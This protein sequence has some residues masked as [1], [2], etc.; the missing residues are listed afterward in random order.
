MQDEN[1][2]KQFGE[3]VKQLRLQKRLSQEELAHL[4]NLDRSY[5][6]GVERGIRNISLLNISK[7]AIAL[8]ITTKV[9]FSND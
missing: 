9:F 1:I 6:G 4:A 2:L 3:R 5:V 7:I 8:G